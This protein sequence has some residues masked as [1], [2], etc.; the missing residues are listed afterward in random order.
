M[1]NPTSPADSTDRARATTPIHAPIAPDEAADGRLFQCWQAEAV[2]LRETHWGPL[3]DRLAC[4]MA[5]QSAPTLEARIVARAAWLARQGGLHTRLRQWAVSAR[6]ALCALWLAASLAG[7]GAAAAA[8]GQPHNAVNLSLALLA[9]LG[10]HTLTFLIW[11]MSHLPGIPA[12][13]ALSRLWLWLT[14]RLAHSPDSALA[15]QAFVSLTSRMRAWRSIL[16]LISHGAWTLAFLGMV[17]TLVMLLSTR[18]YTFHWETTLLSPQAFVDLT[19]ALSAWPQQLGF[20]PP[21]SIEIAAS[22]GT[23]P[24]AASVQADWSWWLIGCIVAWGLIPRAAAL[25]FCVLHLRQRL[26]QPLVDAHLPG[27]LELRERLLPT[28]HHLG[29][30]RPAPGDC[31]TH[32]AAGQPA[33]SGNQTAIL[34]YELGTNLDWPPPSLPA[35]IEDWGRCDSRDDRLRIR[36]RLERPPAHLLLAYDARLTPDRGTR[37]WLHELRHRCPDL[38]VLSL[39]TPAIDDANPNSVA[40]RVSAWT[41]MLASLNIEQIQSLSDWLSRVENASHD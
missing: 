9:L 24:L 5:L 28:H 21:G 1:R 37:A 29:I 6:W 40:H 11:L 39:G 18:R 30:D 16:G 35:T 34:A 10:L 8:L 26:R 22:V 25:L 27:W 23:Q 38:A 41:S 13:T 31:L 3:E 32:E 19:R 36:Q 20:P 7:L 17:P 2:R 14:K 12:S 33:P 15:A 4:Q